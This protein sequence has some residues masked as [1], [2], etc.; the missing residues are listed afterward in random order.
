[1][2]LFELLP[3][4][5]AACLPRFDAAAWPVGT[6]YHLGRIVI[7]DVVVEDYADC[8][9]TPSALDA[10]LITRVRSVIAGVVRIDGDCEHPV[11]AE[12]ANRHS[13]QPRQFYALGD[14]KIELPSDVRAGDVLAVLTAPGDGTVPF[15]S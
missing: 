2:T 4:L 10:V 14:T 7:D 1:M 11:D 13:V 3:S 12:V 8:H 15:A 5:K 9:G 6:R